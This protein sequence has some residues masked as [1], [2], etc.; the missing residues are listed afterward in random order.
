MY[1][2]GIRLGIYM[3]WLSALLVCGWYI[4]GLQGLNESY[5]IFL[6]AVTIVIIVQTAQTAPTY[7]VEIVILTYIIFGVAAS[8]RGMDVSRTPEGMM[9]IANML[10][11]DGFSESERDVLLESPSEHHRDRETKVHIANKA[12]LLP[13][14]VL[15]TYCVLAIEFT[16]Y[17]NSVRDV[18]T[19][20]TTGQLL[21]FI[22]GLVGLIKCVYKSVSN[23]VP[24]HGAMQHQ[25]AY[26]D[27]IVPT[28][29]SGPTLRS[30]TQ[31]TQRSI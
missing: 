6:F 3:Q 8:N 20:N 1:G 30:L 22:I 26:G 27:G 19:I 14:C 23:N 13:S 17:W 11:R 31:V 5:I 10:W 4:D 25:A 18:Y 2:L 15:A 21:P 9:E 16:L 28:P 7:A 12:N 24:R 29:V